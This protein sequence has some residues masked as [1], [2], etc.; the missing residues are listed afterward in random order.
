[1]NSNT[2]TLLRQVVT[3]I[4]RDALTRGET[5]LALD[6]FKKVVSFL[7]AGVN[8]HGDVVLG[9]PADFAAALRAIADA[10]ERT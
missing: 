4:R 3:D 5:R 7:V 1:M 9:T 10:V 6:D 2:Y 8:V